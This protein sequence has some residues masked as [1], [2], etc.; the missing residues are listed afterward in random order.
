MPISPHRPIPPI[1]LVIKFQE[2]LFVG[3]ASMPSVAPKLY[4][5]TLVFAQKPNFAIIELFI[6]DLYLRIIL[7]ANKPRKTPKKQS[8]QRQQT[9]KPAPSLKERFQNF[10]NRLRSWRKRIQFL[11]LLGLI[12]TALTIPQ[13]NQW[14]VELFDSPTPT[15]LP[16]PIEGAAFAIDEVGVVLAQFSD[17]AAD[18]ITMR[19]G[20]VQG[21]EE[22]NINFVEIG[23]TI[24][25]REQAKAISDIYNA[26]IVIWGRPYFLGGELQGVEVEYEVTPRRSQVPVT[27]ENI[28]ASADTANFSTYLLKGM[29]TLYVVYFTQAQMQFH[30][31]N[32]ELALESFAQ[33]IERIPSGREQ[34]VKAET[35]Y[36]YRGVCHERLHEYENALEDYSQGIRIDDTY[37]IAYIGLGNNHYYLGQYDEAL[38][39]YSRAI[40]LDNSYTGAYINRANVYRVLGQYDQ[41]LTD[42]TR[43][44]E[45]D[46]SYAKSYN[47]RGLIYRYLGQND[48]AIADYNRAIDLDNSYTEAY[49]NRG[50]AYRAL[51]QY[52]QAIADYTSAI[53]L[54]A[55][56]VSAYQ[57][58]GNIYYEMGRE[59]YEEAIADYERYTEL[60]GSLQP[61]MT[62]RIAE[63]QAA[64]Q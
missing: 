13:F 51:G 8:R 32:C 26:T 53:E 25:N 37:V 10:V 41:A 23:H 17:S 7:M 45:L 59:Y 30:E 40:D 43:A 39:D 44:I 24:Q 6:M 62:E 60:T 36:Q 5:R 19:R 47:C 15:P 48:Q 34:D 49:I 18:A 27:I 46:A 38:A 12:L 64:L 58:R 42:Y 33:S 21:F 61:Y 52:E 50:D 4:A 35:L 20:I 31:D 14:T 2:G 29:D 54:N 1:S 55:D 11:G 63:I 56:Y 3:T 28:I 16:T 9:P 57:G 22:N